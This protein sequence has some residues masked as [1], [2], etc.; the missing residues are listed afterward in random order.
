VNRRKSF[1]PFPFRAPIALRNLLIL[2]YLGALIPLL[3]V[4]G[5]VVYS[6]QQR[7]L[8]ADARDRLVDFVSADVAA[9]DGSDLTRLAVTLG[10]D[11]RVLGADVFV[12]DGS[13]KPVP[14]ALGTG[15][16]LTDDQHRLARDSKESSLLTIPGSDGSLRTRRLVYL[17]V[18]LDAQ[19]S[20]LGTVEASLPLAPVDAELAALRQW[21][22]II[23]STAAALSVLLALGISWMA[24]RPLQALVETAGRVGRGDLSHR[25]ELPMIREVRL[26]AE[27]FNAMLDR[28][29][30]A[31][32]QQARTA[33]E[34]RRF[35]ADASH[36]LRSPLAVL[37]SGSDILEKAL[38]HG[39][40]GEA[41]TIL[42]TLRQEIDVMSRLV[43]NL[44]F[45]ARL[46][47][48][49]AGSAGGP[50]FAA[51][52]PFPLLEE[53]FERAQLIAA[54]RLLKLEWP[55]Q[56]PGEIRADREMLRR[57]L[58]NLVENGIKYT[59]A[60]KSVTLSLAAGERCCRFIVRDEGP[61]IP[62]DQLPRIFE[63]FFRADSARSRAAAAGR[64]AGTGLGLAIVNAIAQAHGG[65]VSAQSS[66][67]RGSV[68]VLEIPLA[69]P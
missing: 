38:D 68:F 67:G 10:D 33:D 37:R 17:A 58:N 12:K 7:F 30:A 39:D 14:P 23:L 40:R 54:D 2:L 44:L 15:P 56:T 48:A 31:L 21:L 26:L 5:L 9:L 24:T 53:V 16:W 50:A 52:E 60:G 29:Q 25:A 20:V 55:A 57:A 36:E 4:I 59:P 41:G 43:D 34:M 69:Q 63:R 18:V 64:P 42:G 51:V 11:L 61:G 19:Q 3:V 47:Q 8:L 27:T 65:S 13:G 62:A 32:A 46:D 45:L 66:E 35:A 22:T 28:I 6:L 1:H 49:G